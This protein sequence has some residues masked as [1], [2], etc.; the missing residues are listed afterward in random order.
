MQGGLLFSFIFRTTR[1]SRRN[2]AGSK[3]KHLNA[4]PANLISSPFL[5]VVLFF[6]YGHYKRNDYYKLKNSCV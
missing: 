5:P 1:L 6:V 2:A 3:K 4:H